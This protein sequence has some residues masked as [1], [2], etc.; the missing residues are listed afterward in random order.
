MKELQTTCTPVMKYEVLK[1][2][3]MYKLSI[4]LGMVVLFSL[5]FSGVKFTHLSTN[6]LRAGNSEDPKYL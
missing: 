1:M 6:F 4:V 5:L 3:R 2:G